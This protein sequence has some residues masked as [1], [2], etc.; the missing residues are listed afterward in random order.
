MSPKREPPGRLVEV[1]QYSG[2]GCLFA[3]GVL[4]FMGGGW[5]LDRLLNTFPVFMVVGALGGAVLSTVSIYRRL[6]GD[7]DEGSAETED[8]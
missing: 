5:L 1:H 2:L 6:L 4:V 7:T 3:A 8:S